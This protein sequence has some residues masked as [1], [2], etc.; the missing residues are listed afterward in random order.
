[1]AQQQGQWMPAPTDHSQA[2]PPGLEYLTQ[3]DQLL[4][5]QKVELLE[6]FTG[7]E[8]ANKYVVKNTLGQQ[9][10]YAAE[11]SGCCERQCCKNARSFEMKI[12]DNNQR[13]VIHVERPLR[14]TSSCYCSECCRQFMEVQSPPG[15]PCGYIKANCSCIYPSFSVLDASMQEV[16]RIKGPCGGHGCCT[17]SPK[18]EVQ[19]L[20]G[21]PVG[22]IQKQWGG[23]GKEAFTTADNFGVSFPMDLDVKVKATLLG[24]CFLIDFIFFEDSGAN[25]AN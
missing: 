22:L 23:L 2:C 15:Q 13:E 17:C 14:C 9:I 8:G 19:S 4:V 18:Y 21:S 16:L 3:I 12:V 20:D 11:N 5:H 24:A 6:A 1:M 7:W 25:D 10:Y